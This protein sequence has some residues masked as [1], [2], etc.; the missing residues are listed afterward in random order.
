MISTPIINQY[1]ISKSELNK[2]YEYFKQIKIRNDLDNKRKYN[3]SR[4]SP[5]NFHIN[6]S[7]KENL[8][9]KY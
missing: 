1:P 2:I 9:K 3:S 8:S 7:N 6:F 4:N 5:S